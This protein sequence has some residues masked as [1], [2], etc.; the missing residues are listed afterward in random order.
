MDSLNLD[1]KKLLPKV[2]FAKTKDCNKCRPCGDAIPCD[3]PWR[4]VIEQVRR[5]SH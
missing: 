1:I 3:L 2:I 4:Q 5:F